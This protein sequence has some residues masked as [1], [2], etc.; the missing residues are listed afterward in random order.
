MEV[1][2][3]YDDTLPEIWKKV[4]GNDL[5]YHVGSIKGFETSSKYISNEII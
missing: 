2:E 3:F 5:H 4:I 1:D